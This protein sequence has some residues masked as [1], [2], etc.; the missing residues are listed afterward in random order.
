MAGHRSARDRSP[1]SFP[2]E[3][4]DS[5]SD[6][7]LSEA[8]MIVSSVSETDP[9]ETFRPPTMDSDDT[10]VQEIPPP[11]PVVVDLVDTPPQNIA[12]GSPVDQ[13]VD[14]TVT[15]TFRSL[16]SLTTL[17]SLTLSVFTPIISTA[18]TSSVIL[19]M[20]VSDRY[21]FESLLPGT[22]PSTI[23]MGTS[24]A[25]TVDPVTVSQ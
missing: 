21:Q 11:H 20:P 1:T 3:V 8:Y 10:S 15:P 18:V 17:P 24:S 14:G 23:G 22:T 9:H 7:D 25:M 2:P 6:T 16:S 4:V 12:F 19:G 13:I 5:S